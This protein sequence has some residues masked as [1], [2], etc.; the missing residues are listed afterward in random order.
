MASVFAE[1]F[2]DV[3]SPRL[4][5]VLGGA[6]TLSRGE[7]STAG[8]GARWVDDDSETDASTQ[9]RVKTSL[10]YREFAIAK[11]VYVIDSV[12]VTPA[13]GDRLLDWD[14]VTW[15]V[16]HQPNMPAREG[17]GGELEWL[18]RTK[19]ITVT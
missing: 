9:G 15:E 13:P 8:I 5:D 3:A 17:Y 7:S 12:A 19:E 18:V 6:V 4:Q 16:M 14:G 2:F 1:R 11:A 10:R